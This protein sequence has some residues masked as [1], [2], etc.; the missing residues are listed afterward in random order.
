MGFETILFEIS[1]DV[2]LLT[3]NRPDKLNAFSVDM[4]KEIRAALKQSEK[5]KAR[6]LVITGA[7]RAFCAGAD[8]G[9]RD[10]STDDELDLGDLLEKYYNPLI[11]TLKDLPMPVIGAVNGVA[12]GAGA[13]LALACDL[14]FAA[15]SASFIQAFIRIGLVPDAGGSFHLPRLVGPQ[16]A[17]ALAMT[18]D[19][20]DA[21][22]A[23]HWGMIYKCVDDDA[24]MDEVMG[25]ARHLATQP[26]R[27]LGLIKR[28]MTASLGNDLKTQLDLERNMQRVAG[29]GG[30]YR[31]GV[32]A[33][34]EK[35]APNFTGT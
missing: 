32:Q 1:D 22:T 20:L 9:A 35:R 15:R 16:R 4:H 25:C 2:A 6:A 13:N 3:L 17:M 27:S 31:E 26:T 21:E 5:H 29:L 11:L 7:G 30:D 34:L 19:K 33:F 10:I 23:E 18:G 14:V 8:L 28:L 24:L 12:A